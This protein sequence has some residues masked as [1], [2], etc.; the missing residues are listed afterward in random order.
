MGAEFDKC[1][2]SCSEHLIKT[3]LHASFENNRNAL[4]VCRT[5]VVTRGASPTGGENGISIKFVHLKNEM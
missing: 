1:Q 5:V 2:H 3:N 4:K